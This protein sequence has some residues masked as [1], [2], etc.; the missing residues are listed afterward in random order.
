MEAAWTSEMSVS[1]H[2]TIWCYNPEDLDM[3]IKFLDQST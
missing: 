3:K 2:I 1:Y